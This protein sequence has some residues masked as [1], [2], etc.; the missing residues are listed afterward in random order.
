MLIVGFSSFS[1]ESLQYL[2]KCVIE[3]PILYYVFNTLLITLLV[4]HVYW[5]LLIWRMLMKQMKDRGKISDDVRSG[6]FLSFVAIIVSKVC[7]VFW[8]SLCRF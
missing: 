8:L 6:N 4:I 7:L 2:D 1:Y 5:W 3:G